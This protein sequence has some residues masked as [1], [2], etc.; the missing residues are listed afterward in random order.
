MKPHDSG[1]IIYQTEDGRT[2]IDARADGETIWLARTRMAAPFQTTERNASLH[3][4][5]AFEEG[6]IDAN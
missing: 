4:N 3:L 2:K 1:I 6:E 5:D